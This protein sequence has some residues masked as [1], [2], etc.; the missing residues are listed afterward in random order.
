MTFDQVLE[1]YKHQVRALIEG[2]CDILMIE[3]I[4]DSLNAKAAA[5][6][7]QEVFEEDATPACRSSS[8]P[9]SDLAGKR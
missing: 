8:P 5:V 1:A 7:V 4:F 2:G 6:A 9:P 3:T